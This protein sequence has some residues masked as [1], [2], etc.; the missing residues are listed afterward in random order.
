MSNSAAACP[1]EAVPQEAKSSLQELVL[2]LCMGHSLALPTPRPDILLV[3]PQLCCT[4][5]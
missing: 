3:Q 1:K 2:S 5:H 4:V